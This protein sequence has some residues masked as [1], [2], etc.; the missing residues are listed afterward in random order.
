MGI[1]TTNHPEPENTAKRVTFSVVITTYNRSHLLKRSLNSLIAQTENDWEAIIV[2]DGSTDDTHTQLVPYLRSG[3]EIRYIRKPH[4][5]TVPSKNAGI[6]ASHGKFI[7]FLDSD[8]EYH[9]LH[10]ESRKTF[11]IRNPSVR[12]LYGGA[13]I[14]G[15]PYVPDKNDPSAR[16]SLSNC[17]IGGTFVIERE[18]LLS[19]NGFNEI[20]LGADADLFDRVRKARISMEEIKIPT[21]IYHHENAESVTNRMF[22]RV[23]TYD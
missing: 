22:L 17:V 11:L 20:T 21:Y 6:R 4:S 19:L 9:P 15:N 1:R 23:K 18:T 8:D 12:F 3:R 10:L 5:G 13:K 7:T 14:L 16:I 2:D